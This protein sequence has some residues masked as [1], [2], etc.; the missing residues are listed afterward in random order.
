MPVEDPLRIPAV[1]LHSACQHLPPKVWAL[2]AQPLSVQFAMP[3]IANYPNCSMLY[4]PRASC[5]IRGMQRAS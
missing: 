3:K 4:A 1:K 5:T 2:L